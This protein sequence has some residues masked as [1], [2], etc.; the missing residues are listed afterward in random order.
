[1]QVTNIKS[2]TALSYQCAQATQKPNF[3]GIQFV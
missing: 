1:M 2:D 3:T